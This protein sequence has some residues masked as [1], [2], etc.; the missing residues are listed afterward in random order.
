MS[1]GSSPGLHLLELLQDPTGLCVLTAQGELAFVGHDRRLIVDQALTGPW[2]EHNLRFLSDY[3]KDPAADR[4]RAAILHQ[5]RVTK[6]WGTLTLNLQDDTLRQLYPV[7]GRQAGELTVFQKR[8]RE[9]SLYQGMELML[10]YRN[11]LSPGTVVFAPVLHDRHTTLD[12]YSD[13]LDR[14]A[15]G[16]DRVA[17]VLEVLN[18]VAMMPIEARK[19]ERVQH[20]SSVLHRRL[21]RKDKR[22]ASGLEVEGGYVSAGAPDDVWGNKILHGDSVARDDGAVT[23]TV[24][25][26]I[27]TSLAREKPLAEGEAVNPPR[28]RFFAHFEQL[29]PVK[30]QMIADRALVRMVPASATLLR[31]GSD[32]PWNLYLLEGTVSLTAEDG[33]VTTLEGGTPRARAPLAFLRPRKYTV[34]ALTKVFYLSVHDTLL[35]VVQSSGRPAQPAT[36]ATFATSVDD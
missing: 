2:R 25:A 5:A 12:R 3:Y 34:T 29:D 4:R 11:E 21:I 35:K 24:T 6:P 30:L 17:P 14:G 16:I 20:L 32:E 15:D 23:S 19:D 13:W 18:L 36:P 9:K 31:R 33:T 26:T 1:E 28:L 8:N 22:H 10:E 27:T 7:S